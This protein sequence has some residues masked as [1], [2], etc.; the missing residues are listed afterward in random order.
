MGT[1]TWNLAPG[2]VSC[3]LDT[4]A[5][6]G[7]GA[8]AA[9]ATSV[10]DMFDYTFPENGL[11]AFKDGKQIGSTSMKDHIGEDNLKKFINRTLG[12]LATVD[13]PVKRCVV[14]GRARSPARVCAARADVSTGFAGGGHCPPSATR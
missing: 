14:P 8:C 3:H 1:D 13:V 10:V 2:P 12:Y 9:M 4:A 7:S 6:A 5:A 11:Q